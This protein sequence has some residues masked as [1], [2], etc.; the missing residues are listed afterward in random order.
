MGS[1]RAERGARLSLP[2]PL[3][4]LSEARRRMRALAPRRGSEGEPHVHAVGRESWRGSTP[5]HAPH[6]AYESTRACLT[7]GRVEAA[8]SSGRALMPWRGGAVERGALPVHARDSWTSARERACGMMVHGHGRRR[9]SPRCV[10]TDCRES[11]HDPFVA[12]VRDPSAV[13]TRASF[14]TPTGTSRRLPSVD[15]CCESGACAYHP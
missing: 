3:S 2:P 8:A 6:R 14:G 15:M 5:P 9:E 7:G 11:A 10:H 4:R 12:H 13:I 1:G